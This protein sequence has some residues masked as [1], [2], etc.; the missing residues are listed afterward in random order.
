[1]PSPYVGHVGTL[2][3]ILSPYPFLTIWV[4]G[5][6]VQ[7]YAIITLD[8]SDIHSSRYP[9]RSILQFRVN[10]KKFRQRMAHH[11]R[12]GNAAADRVMGNGPASGDAS[13]P[14]TRCKWV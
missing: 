6:C 3:T 12:I 5:F 2:A 1:M 11:K 14:E 13:Q 8:G 10:V 4:T 9:D 7:N